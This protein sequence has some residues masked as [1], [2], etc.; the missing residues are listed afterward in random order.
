MVVLYRRFLYNV[1]SGD[2]AYDL[3]KSCKQLLNEKIYIEYIIAKS[4]NLFPCFPSSWGDGMG[5]FELNGDNLEIKLDKDTKYTTPSLT[6]PY[7]SICGKGL[8]KT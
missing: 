2:I 5:L 6:P 3:L 1:N 4:N 7:F 8:A